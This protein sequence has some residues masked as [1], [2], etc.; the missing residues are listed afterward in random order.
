MKELNV[1]DLDKTLLPYDSFRKYIFLFLKNKHFILK[2]S[3]LIIVRKM[4]LLSLVT[5]KRKIIEISRK[6]ERYDEKMIYF[7]D[8]LCSE[9]NDSV[10][11]IIRN[12]T[13]NNTVNVLCTASPEDYVKKIAIKMDWLYLCTTLNDGNFVHMY[14]EQKVISIKSK[15]P[16]NKY[17]YN[18]AISDS[19]TDLGLLKMFND[20]KLLTK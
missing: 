1:I 14:G 11:E 18:Y 12:Q 2:I 3:F 6:D 8:D 7:S 19:Y 9:I 10:T 17:N 16:K 4:R 13:N 20:F 15:F 5:F